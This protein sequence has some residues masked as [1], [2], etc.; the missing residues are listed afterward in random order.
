MNYTKM[1]AELLDY[2][3]QFLQIPA[4]HH[5]TKMVQGELFVLNYMSTHKCDIYPKDLSA[6]LAVSS[7]RISALLKHMESR[8][9]IQR[10][11][12][13][14]DNRRTIVKITQTGAS[15]IEKVRNDA[16][17]HIA[18][19]LEAIGEKDTREYLRIHREII[20]AC[21]H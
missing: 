10:I 11:C 5:L 2:R 3:T 8:N 17:S 9:L 18:K 13:Q 6:S 21:E 4:N 7:A 15:Y 1:A 14:K 12:D 16:I 19:V 20:K